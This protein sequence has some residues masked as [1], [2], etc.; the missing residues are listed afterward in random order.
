MMANGDLIVGVKSDSPFTFVMAHLD[1]TT[2]AS[3]TL[4]WAG[5]STLNSITMNEHRFTM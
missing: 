5:Y 4:S 3:P 2:P 1:L